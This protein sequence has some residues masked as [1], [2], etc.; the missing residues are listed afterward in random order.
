M[1]KLRTNRGFTLIELVV[2]VAIFGLLIAVGLPSFSSAISNSRISSQYNNTIG[3]F[4]IA[5][6]EAVKASANVTVCARS[7]DQSQTC[8]QNGGDWSDG[9]V[10]FQDNDPVSSD[11]D[12][13]IGAE[14]TILH[15]EPELTGENTLI[16][17]GSTDNTAAQA[18]ARSYVV[19]N[20]NGST[21]WRGVS[22]I[23]CD[24]RGAT[25][26][27]AMNIVI[28]GDI[29][30]GRIPENGDTPLDTFGLEATCP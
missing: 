27:R 22:A 8:K 3:A 19:Y 4:F 14:D 15:V 7:H 2:A 18:E 16:T 20:P 11:G 5:R 13:I 28:T 6:S 17:Y 23:L 21:N 26:S 24:D 25:M 12:I 30:R 9:I 1:E 29:R 10:V